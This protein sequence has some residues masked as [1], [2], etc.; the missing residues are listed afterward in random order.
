MQKVSEFKIV[1]ASE[2]GGV[3]GGTL[4]RKIKIKLHQL[5]LN[6]KQESAK[7]SNALSNS[8]PANLRVT[9][10]NKDKLANSRDNAGGEDKML[11]QIWVFGRL[12]SALKP[13]RQ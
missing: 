5:L 7:S 13:Q 1:S 6:M 11:L 2:G 9:Y 8:Q 10:A 12:K 4:N 3:L